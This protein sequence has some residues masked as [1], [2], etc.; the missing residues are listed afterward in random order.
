MY[1]IIY[2]NDY[3]CDFITNQIQIKYK[4]IKNDKIIAI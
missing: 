1:Y 4:L 3:Y 2:T